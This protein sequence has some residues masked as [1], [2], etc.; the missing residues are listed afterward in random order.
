MDT[1]QDQ[2]SLTENDIENVSL[3]SENA[4]LIYIIAYHADFD[5]F[6]RLRYAERQ[7]GP[8]TAWPVEASLTN[9]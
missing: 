3:I 7:T 8:F 9:S 6:K 5:L 4:S 2:S 1:N